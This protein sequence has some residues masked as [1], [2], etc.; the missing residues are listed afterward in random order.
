MP[1]LAEADECVTAEARL[2]LVKRD[3]FDGKLAYK[4]FELIAELC[5]TAPDPYH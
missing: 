1:A 5:R 2:I 3:E 4:I